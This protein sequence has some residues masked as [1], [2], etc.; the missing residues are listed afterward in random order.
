MN[1]QSFYDQ[2]IRF[3]AG[4]DEAGR[5]PLAGPCVVS[6]VI[7]SPEHIHPDLSDSKKLS[8]T[9]RDVLYQWIKLNALAYSI[10]IVEP[11]DIDALNIYQAT[12]QGMMRAIDALDVQPEW[13]LTDAMPLDA[14]YPHQSFTQADGLF[15]CVGAAS[16]L[17]KVTR[18]RIMIELDQ[19]Y[20]EYGFK[21]HKGYPTKQHITA[22]KAS[23]PTPHHRFS[24]R[25]VIEA[26][27][28]HEKRKT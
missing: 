12:R 28:L 19:S 1:D 16:I 14:R 11:R 13:I 6:A 21:H 3:L 2:G 24:Y 8:A 18:D 26:Q 7:L 27:T 4:V 25:P 10:V 9:K 20:P 17:A 5:G 23:G 15:K 22:L